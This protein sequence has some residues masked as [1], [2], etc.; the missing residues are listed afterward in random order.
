VNM[1]SPRSYPPGT[2]PRG[3]AFYRYYEEV[4]LISEECLS[5]PGTPIGVGPRLCGLPRTFLLDTWV[6]NGGKRK[7]R[8]IIAPARTW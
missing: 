2:P 1:A 5:Q 6:N 8:S 3:T 7:D 4:R